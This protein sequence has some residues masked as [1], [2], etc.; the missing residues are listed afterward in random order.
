MVETTEKYRG[1]SSQEL[2]YECKF[3]GNTLV[4]I[5]PREEKDNDG[6]SYYRGQGR[7]KVYPTYRREQLKADKAPMK[8]I[9]RYVSPVIIK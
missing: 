4:D 1:H 3:R 9:N 6:Y 8:K 7:E 2:T 5:S